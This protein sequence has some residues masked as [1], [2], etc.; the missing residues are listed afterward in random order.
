MTTKLT[1]SMKKETVEKAK[2]LSARHG[3]SVSKMMEDFIND[4]PETPKKSI[5]EEMIELMAPY[6][7]RINKSIPEDKSY[8]DM[9]RDW[10]YEDYLKKE[11]EREQATKKRTKGK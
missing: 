9:V 3:K 2:R 1:L 6:R 4:F 10:R 5:V 7:D 8:R 11:A